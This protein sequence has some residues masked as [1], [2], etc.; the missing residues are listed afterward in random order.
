MKTNAKIKTIQKSEDS[1]RKGEDIKHKNNLK[2]IRCKINIRN[3]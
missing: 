1:P 3:G 2:C